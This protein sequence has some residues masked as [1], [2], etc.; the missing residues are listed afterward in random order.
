MALPE[1]AVQN[2]ITSFWTVTFST[3]GSVCLE[4]FETVT[5]EKKKKKRKRLVFVNTNLVTLGSDCWELFFWIFAFKT[6]LT[7]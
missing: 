1:G 5:F 4:F 2:P 3:Y 7:G 6:I